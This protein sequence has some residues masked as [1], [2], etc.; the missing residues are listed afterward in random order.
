MTEIKRSITPV[1]C[2]GVDRMCSF[3]FVCPKCKNFY[4]FGCYYLKTNNEEIVCHKER[5]KCISC[6]ENRLIK[7]VLFNSLD[8]YASFCSEL[9]SG[10]IND[11]RCFD[12]IYFFICIIN[13]GEY[14]KVLMESVP[15]YKHC[16]GES[17]GR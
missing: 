9:T 3:A 5:T 6:G 10:K 7:P 14:V 1:A 8:E 2:R 12:D 11:I 13:I 16:K 17:D 15:V 4:D